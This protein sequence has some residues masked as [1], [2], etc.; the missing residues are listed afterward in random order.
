MTAGE[1][2]LRLKRTYNQH[3]DGIGLF[4]W[5]WISSFDYRLSFGHS[6]PYGGCYARP[7]IPQCTNTNGYTI[8]WTHR[9]DGR[10]IQYTKNATDGIY[11]ED[12]PSPISK[13]VRQ[14]DGRWVLYGESNDVQVYAASGLPIS[15][16]NTRGI[17]WTFEHG[18]M[19]GSQLQRVNHT[20]G[21]Y[22]Q[23][24]WTGDELT[25]IRDPA[26]N[27]YRYT[28][29]HQKIDDGLHLL[30]T[31]TLPGAESTVIKYH[32]DGESGEPDYPR[33]AL[34]GKSY[35]DVRYSRFTYDSNMRATSSQHAGGVDKYSYVYTTGT[36]G[37]LTAAETNPLAKQATYFFN[38]DGHLTEVIGQASAHCPET[39]RGSTYD[40]NGYPDVVTDFNGNIE[41]FDYNAKGQLLKHVEA[42]G[43]P[44]ARTS[45]YVWDTAK[46]RINSYTVANHSRIEYTYKTDN[47]IASIKIVNLSPNGVANQAHTTTYEYTEHQS[48]LLA[49]MTVDG[50][51]S[52]T[53]DAVVYTYDMY[54]NLTSVKNDLDHTVSYSNYNA[55]GLPGRITNENGGL[56]D[57][58]YDERGRTTA[59]KNYIN[60]A[61]HTT[62]YD[63][64]AAGLLEGV[65]R[66]DGQ[67]RSYA[68][69]AVR[70]L[71]R[72]YEAESATVYAQKRYTYNN[73]SLITRIDTERTTTP[74][75]APSLSASPTSS[76]TGSY[77]VSWSSVA[78][79][80]SY[81]LEEKVNSGAWTE[82]QNTA[83]TGKAISGKNN[84]TY[85]Y[86]VQACNAAGCG[87][88]S[89]TV[90]VVVTLS[91]PP[92]TPA[93]TAPPQ[94]NYGGNYSAAWGSVPGATSYRLEEKRD[95][96]AW[97]EIY[98]AAGTSLALSKNL[99]ATFSYRV[100]ACNTAG[101]SAYSAVRTVNVEVE[102]CPSCLVSP[103]PEEPSA[104]AD[105]GGD[106]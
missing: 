19:H 30:K 49:T 38:S 54:G 61:W 63:Y 95:S 92:A 82:I 59:V 14:S 86:R 10:K 83:A 48:G 40:P 22:V 43:K 57:Y 20:S 35:N 29:A 26:L 9:P 74:V 55:L 33:Y 91:G 103:P 69:D 7:S 53:G 24:I 6:S 58:F 76:A 81:R 106:Q 77:T 32:Y 47:R 99:S 37:A 18:G 34:T 84:A 88:Y 85:G 70:R 101:C 100:R 25:E 1:A 87:P 94:N 62:T 2:A 46:N 21:R 16:K 41:D 89:A 97:A 42:Y 51:L 90:N 98:N 12:K 50:P 23:F 67:T 8:I 52:G 64:N 11:Y 44:E 66:P 28:Y 15:I 78:D 31:T 56:T 13:I 72:E 79:T 3:S 60:G 105:N 65:T 17:G 96:G 75:S 93:M 4:G 80:T 71:A 104:A 27:S 102:A 68:Y 73:A 45:T 39:S 36:D 5:K